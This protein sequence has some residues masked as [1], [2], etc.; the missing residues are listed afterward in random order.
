MG[1]LRG[2]PKGLTLLGIAWATLVV[3]GFSLVI[4]HTGTPGDAGNPLSRWPSGSHV[5]PDPGRANL[6]MLAHPRCPCMRAGLAELERIMARCRDKVTA[7]VLF[8]RPKR[9]S[10]AWEQTDIVRTAAA[11]PGV[12][13]LD[14]EEGAEANRFGAR[15]S[16]HVL[17][18]DP[19][20]RLCFSGGITPSRGHEGDSAG[21]RA[22]IEQLTQ[23]WTPHP[24]AMVFGCPLFEECP[25]AIEGETECRK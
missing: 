11:I 14:D 19:T 10:E 12:H 21:R 25:T 3:A 20:G 1:L 7:H 16:G 17:L 8:R 23:G 18:Y 22:V 6:V 13:V 4:K 15:T 24:R 2:I 5:I 9:S